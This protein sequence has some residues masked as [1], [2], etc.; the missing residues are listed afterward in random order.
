ME[1]WEELVKL[2]ESS[3]DKF[4]EI[5][6]ILATSDPMTREHLNYELL[7]YIANRSK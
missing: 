1:L 6:G 7:G 5:S 2:A 4:E 3:E